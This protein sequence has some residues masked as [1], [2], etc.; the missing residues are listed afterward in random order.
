MS[1]AQPC[2]ILQSWRAGNRRRDWS[3]F[4]SF[5]FSTCSIVQQYWIW[6]L[7]QCLVCHHFWSSMLMH[8]KRG[9]LSHISEGN[10]GSA[11]TTWPYCFRWRCLGW[12]WRSSWC[13]G[14][15]TT[16]TSSSPSTSLKSPARSGSPMS[17]W[18]CV[19]TLAAV[20]FR[21]TTGWQFVNV[22]FE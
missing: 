16:S 11:I 14:H 4:I 18:R 9:Q 12:W 1:Q 10:W 13:A 5:T 3:D 21:V 6:L 2:F 8:F 17:T 7:F 19:I 22:R 20:F 15:P